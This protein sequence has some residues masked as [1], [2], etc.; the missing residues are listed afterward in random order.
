MWSAW[1]PIGEKLKNV[2]GEQDTSSRPMQ[3]ARVLVGVGSN[4]G[5]ILFGILG[6]PDVYNFILIVCLVNMGLYF[7][8]Y[9]LMKVVLC[10]LIFCNISFGMVWLQYLVSKLGIT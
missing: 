7:A 8:N 9:V 10:S 5:L 6:D 1:K 4:I 2:V 3:V